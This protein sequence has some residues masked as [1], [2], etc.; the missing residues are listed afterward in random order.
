MIL[1]LVLVF[2]ILCINITT[3]LLLV[4]RKKTSKTAVPS[5]SNPSMSISSLSNPD[6][7][8]G[9][10]QATVTFYKA[11]DSPGAG[12][13]GGCVY[14][15]KKNITQDDFK[16]HNFDN[17]FK[18][19]QKHDTSWTMAATSEAMM[20]PY[21]TGSLGMGCVGRSD[22]SGPTAVAPCGSCWKLLKNDTKQEINVVVADACPCG[23]KTVC[24]TTADPGGHA[25]NSP[26]CRAAPGDKNNQGFCNHFDVWNGD[27]VFGGN[28]TVSFSNIPCP[29]FIKDLM[30]QSC[31]GTY[32]DG[33]KGGNPQGCPNI[34]GT[35]HTCPPPS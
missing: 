18:E 14:P 21:C 15:G 35:D 11:G 22:P 32:Y 19:I 8:E 34:C 23:N 33:S 3:L 26:F 31:C 17:L 20:A 24:P 13:C 28:G 29:D 4:Y 12:S 30:K 10:K 5:T 9:D 2:V 1:F 27:Q 6:F 25:D 16:D 7:Y